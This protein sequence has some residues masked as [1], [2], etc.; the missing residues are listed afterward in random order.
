MKIYV[1]YKIHWS[2]S[3]PDPRE[4]S[5]IKFSDVAI[6]VDELEAYRYANRNGLKVEEMEPTGKGFVVLQERAMLR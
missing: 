6:F 1:A 4:A 2:Y 3:P 5:E